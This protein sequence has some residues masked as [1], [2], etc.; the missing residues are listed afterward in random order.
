MVHLQDLPLVVKP[1]IYVMGLN[2]HHSV[3]TELQ[4]VVSR[5]L[6]HP[7]LNQDQNRTAVNP[8]ISR[9]IEGANLN[10]K[11]GQVTKPIARSV[12]VRKWLKLG[13]RQQA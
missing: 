3:P 9:N 12:N 11:A 8:L 4:V 2:I 6:H 10:I 7:S 13:T 5:P 1:S